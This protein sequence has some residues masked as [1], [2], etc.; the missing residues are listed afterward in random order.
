MPCKKC[1]STKP[2]YPVKEVKNPEINFV[3]YACQDCKTIQNSDDLQ[4]DPDFDE[5]DYVEYP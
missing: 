5:G 1:G 2:F 3:I 4:F